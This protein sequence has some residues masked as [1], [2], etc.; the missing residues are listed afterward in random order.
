M[1]LCSCFTVSP[2][3]DGCFVERDPIENVLPSTTHSYILSLFCGFR[4][5]TYFSFNFLNTV[6]GRDDWDRF[7]ANYET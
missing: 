6:K 1:G 7:E 4:M 5:G 3:E 2:S